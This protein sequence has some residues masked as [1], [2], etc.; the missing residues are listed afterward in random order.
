MRVD[1]IPHI[2]EI[3]ALA[4]PICWAFAVILFRKTG[5]VVPPLALNLFKNFL[6]LALFV[7]TLFVIGQDL[8]RPVPGREYVL[9]L[10]SGAIGIG[11]SDTLFFMTLNRLG[12]GRQ[13]IV[14]TSYSPF[15][16]ALS[17]LFLHER[18]SVLQIVGVLLILNAVL[19]VSRMR[20][21][22]DQVSRT[23]LASG[24]LLGLLATATQAV[25]IVMIKPLLDSTPLIWGNCWRVLGGQ[26]MT[27]LLLPFLPQRREALATLRNVRVWPV[28]IPAA[29]IGTYV[30]LL[31]WLG[32]MKYTLASTAAALNQTATVWTFVL[33]ALLLREPITWLRILGLVLGI[34]GVALVTFG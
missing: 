28:M 23:R 18:L 33:G 24:L 7:G 8:F 34:G 14:N 25:S 6:A 30:S 22:G 32:G 17:M 19:S 11:L 12:A 3:F 13:A 10:V 16:I 1:E 9:L 4:A 5:E 2:G 27:V 31:F 20:E 29:V 15:I 21:G 26:I